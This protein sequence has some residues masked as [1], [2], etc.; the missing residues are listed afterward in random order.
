MDGLAKQYQ[1]EDEFL[2]YLTE[3]FTAS[4]KKGKVMIQVSAIGSFIT[5]RNRYT[6]SDLGLPLGLWLFAFQAHTDIKHILCR[7]G[8]S[9][10]DS[11]ARHT[12]N[13]LTESSLN[14]LKAKVRDAI[15]RGEAEWGKVSDNVQKYAKVHE[16]GLGLQ[17]EL[18]HGTACTAFCFDNCKPGA[19]NADDHIARVIKQDIDWTHID[20]ITNLHFVRVVV[21]FYPHL[22]HLSSQISAWFR[23]A[24]AKHRIH[25][26]KKV[27]QALSTN[28]E[29][30]IQNKGY[31]AGF[32]N[33]DEQM[34][35]EPDKCDN[36]L[37][38]NC[39]DGAT[40]AAL[41]RIKLIQATIPNIYCSFRNA[42]STPETWH[43]KATD[44]NSCA[45]NHYEQASII[46]EHYASQMAYEQSLDKTGQENAPDCTKFPEGLPWTPSKASEPPAAQPDVDINMPGLHNISDDNEDPSIETPAVADPKAA[47]P[48]SAADKDGPKMH[49][50]PLRFNGDRVLSNTILFLVEFGWWVELNYV[51]P[52]GEVGQVLEIFKIFVFT[53]AGSSNQNY[54]CYMLDLYALLEFE[55]SPDL[56]EV[57][58]NNYLFNLRREIGKFVEGD[59]MQEWSNRWLQ[60]FSGRGGGDFDDK[61]YRKTISPNVLHFLKMKENIETAFELKRHSKAHTSPHLRDKTKVLLRL[62]QDEE[63]H[64]FRSGR[65]IGHAA[66][67]QFD[68]GYQRLEDRKM[69]E[70]LECSK[71]YTDVV[72]E[73]EIL[74][75]GGPRNIQ[76]A[77]LNHVPSGATDCQSNSPIP[78]DSDEDQ[79]QSLGRI[80]SLDDQDSMSPTPSSAHSARSCG[81]AASCLAADCVEELDTVD[82][83]NEAL[84][85]GSDL[86]DFKDLLQ[87]LCGPEVEEED[88]S[89]DEEPESEI[90][91]EDEVE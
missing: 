68:R 70:Y 54:M 59:L 17:N 55:C 64:C 67:N 50:E 19:F 47:R 61:F 38:W 76:S 37:S 78:S 45:S 12:L 82:H 22:N 58:L 41:K 85:S 26:H 81:L 83:S 91:G 10:S 57:L 84:C 40:H 66:V 9:V 14:D 39:G 72:E 56:K 5:S 77:N 18:K 7:F 32:F 86:T 62:Y 80:S 69:A 11:T 65:S 53:F 3:C 75:N 29:Q 25:P 30:Q 1:E 90:E 16:H 87:W 74:R 71:E 27:L 88:E 31:Q 15:D 4:P 42:L 43:T 28:A 6:N 36:I 52:E 79:P 20:N 35:I 49:K 73:M 8:Y 63:L 24:L 2:W 13:T 89:E 46:R 60:D 33:F 51:I 23:T 44:L 21:A 48:E 34:G